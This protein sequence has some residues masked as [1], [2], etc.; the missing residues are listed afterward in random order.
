MVES[1]SSL[2]IR[3]PLCTRRSF[4][5]AIALTLAAPIS[6]LAQQQQKVWRI[7][8][9][10]ARSR[11]SG[12]T[13]DVYY[14]AFARELNALGYVE[15]K[16]A[17]IEWRYADGKYERLPELA[18]DLVRSNVDVIVTHGTPGTRAA[19]Q[20]TTSIPIV[21]LSAGDAVGAGLVANLARPEA[22]VTGSTFFQPELLA[23]RL[24]L[25]KEARPRITRVGYLVNAAN[26]SAMGP[27]M[28]AMEAAG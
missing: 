11:V 15:N 24:E 25:L 10:A 12:S 19:K 27:A 2:S 8:F 20:A 28:R 1:K 3:P 16:N 14:E 6:S 18:A 17:V 21:M 4:L 7:G 9:L 5:C 26:P 22:N 23:K 13:P